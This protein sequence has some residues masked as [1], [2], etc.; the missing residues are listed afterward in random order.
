MLFTPSPRLFVPPCTP[1]P[2]PPVPTPWPSSAYV[3]LA[4]PMNSPGWPSPPQNARE[5]ECA[6]VVAPFPTY[7][8][9]ATESEMAVVGVDPPLIAS[10]RAYRESTRGDTVIRGIVSNVVEG[11]PWEGLL[12]AW[13]CARKAGPVVAGPAKRTG[14]GAITSAPPNSRRERRAAK[15]ANYNRLE[16]SVAH[17]GFGGAMVSMLNCCA[18]D[19]GF[20]PGRSLRIFY[21]R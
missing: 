19:R 1:G 21:E 7:G 18:Q 12:E 2:C 14:G 11:K 10:L 20:K 15:R 6:G 13:L 3:F 16:A 8:E 4:F 9:P 5:T 17:R